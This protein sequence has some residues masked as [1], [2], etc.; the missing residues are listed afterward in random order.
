MTHASASCVSCVTPL[1]FLPD[2]APRR[3]LTSFLPWWGRVEG[4]QHAGLCRL[5]NSWGSLQ[6]AF[7][8]S[9]RP[10]PK[11]FKPPFGYL[12]NLFRRSSNRFPAIR[13]TSSESLQTAFRLSEK[14]LS[15]ALK[16]PFACLGNHFRVS[17]NPLVV[18][19]PVAREGCSYSSKVCSAY[20]N[21]PS[22]TH[23]RSSG[24]KSPILSFLA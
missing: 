15:E 22:T 4:G 14:L 12:R 9:G 6:T 13:E 8:L 2:E 23:R 24:E 17:T 18:G 1:S 21:S 7:L 3:H 20:S 16:P 10:L 11:V 5:E 19:F